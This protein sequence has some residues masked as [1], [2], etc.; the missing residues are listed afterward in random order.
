[1]GG[2]KGVLGFLEGEKIIKIRKIN[3]VVDLSKELIYL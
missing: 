3:Q 1:M 2:K